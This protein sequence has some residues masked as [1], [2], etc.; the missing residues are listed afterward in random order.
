MNAWWLNELILESLRALQ[1]HKLR[2]TLTLLGVIFGV[3][4]VIAMLAVGEGAQRTVLPDVALRCAVRPKTQYRAFVSF[5]HCPFSRF[6]RPSFCIGLPPRN[7]RA[8][9]SRG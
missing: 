9:S 4:A 6:R 1:R 3:A 7:A 5:T 2:S 8:G